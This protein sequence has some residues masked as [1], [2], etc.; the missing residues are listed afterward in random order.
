MTKMRYKNNNLL[1]IKEIYRA[2]RNNFGSFKH[3]VPINPKKGMHI[4]VYK[5]KNLPDYSVFL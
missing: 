5:K 1:R 2:R 4:Q 3:I